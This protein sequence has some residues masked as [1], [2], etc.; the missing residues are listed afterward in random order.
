VSAIRQTALLVQ[1]LVHP[2][3][4]LHQRPVRRLVQEPSS[5]AQVF[6]P[7]LL[8]RPNLANDDGSQWTRCATTSLLLRRLAQGEIQ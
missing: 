5:L 4:E 8:S 6:P 1:L 2:R 7:S 3:R